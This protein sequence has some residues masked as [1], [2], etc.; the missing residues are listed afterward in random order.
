MTER[1]DL[2]K[3]PVEVTVSVIGSK[4]KLLI[5]QQ[6]STGDRRFN[7]LQAA[8]PGISKKVLSTAL[9]GLNA[10]GIILREV[11]P[12]APISVVYQLSSLGRSLQPVLDAMGAWGEAYR[13]WRGQPASGP[14]SPSR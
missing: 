3:C 12:T 1:Q 8:L 14:E 6:L 13:K 10:D 2:P 7:E 4:W 11:R 5:L 9:R